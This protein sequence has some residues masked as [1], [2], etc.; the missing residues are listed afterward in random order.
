MTDPIRRDPNAMANPPICMLTT[1]NATIVALYAISTALFTWIKNPGYGLAAPLYA[2]AGIYAIS[3]VLALLFVVQRRRRGRL[4]TIA[5]WMNG[6]PLFLVGLFL[7]IQGNA[8]TI[9]AFIW[10][11]WGDHAMLI[12]FGFFLMTML[13]GAILSMILFVIG[14]ARAPRAP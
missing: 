10:D 11:V 4:V 7:F 13:L 14:F 2:L 6:V 1:L 9:F 5:C 8:T 12:I 3:S